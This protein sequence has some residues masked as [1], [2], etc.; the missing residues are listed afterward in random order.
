MLDFN[1]AVSTRILFGTKKIERLPDEL[2]QYGKKVLFVYGQGSIKKTGVYDTVT[3]LFTQNKIVYHEL[4]GVQPNPRISQVRHG[5]RL[6][7]E[8]DIE[9][10]VAVGGGSVIDSAKTIA[11]GVYHEGDPWDFFVLGD[12]SIKKALPVGTVLTMTGTGS[13]MNG[14]AVISNEDTKEKLAIHHDVLR[15]KFS[16][17]DPTYTFTVSKNQTAAGT[18]DIFSH[19][20]EQYFSPTK[21]AFVQNRLAESLLQTCIFYGPKAL[22][23]PRNYEVRAQ[24]MWTSS[25]A[26]NGLL[27]YGKM[28]DWATHGI[29]H[30]LSA[31]T[32]VTHG[33]G[34]A[35]L[36]PY[37]MEYVLESE[38]IDSFV[39]YARHVWQVKGNDKTA[40][41]KK[42]IKK[43]QEFFRNLGMPGTLRDVGVKEAALN[44]IAE[45][46]VSHGLVGKLKKLDKDDVLM[47]LKN[48]F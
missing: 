38:T 13:E 11:T 45:K 29:E 43:T 20:L 41:A 22:V 16:I 31:V 40:V 1:Y 35:I 8:H 5:I 19:V 14:N 2:R 10:I 37:W 34:L 33:V 46:T 3:A 7:R 9:C 23:E 27:G 6:C 24:L 18:V 17:L 48:A 32:D 47:I 44:E 42:G 25:L 15:P 12:S 39:H 28:T 21:E 4:S 30:A 36:T 26:L